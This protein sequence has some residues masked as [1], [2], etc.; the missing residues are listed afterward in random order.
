[1]I[2]VR[3]PAL[4]LFV[5]L[6]ATVGVVSVSAWTPV[7]VTT[8]PHLRMPGTQPNGALIFQSAAVQRLPRRV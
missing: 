6:L 4:L 1:M 2:K 3:L 5:I 7:D 8:D